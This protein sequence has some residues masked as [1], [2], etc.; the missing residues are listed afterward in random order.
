MSREA[1][2]NV[3]Q[4]KGFISFLAFCC[5]TLSAVGLVRTSAV[6]DCLSRREMARGF[7]GCEFLSSGSRDIYLPVVKTSK[8][9]CQECFSLVVDKSIN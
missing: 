3:V 1:F 2:R 4:P 5:K 6:H 7:Q 8:F 9:I